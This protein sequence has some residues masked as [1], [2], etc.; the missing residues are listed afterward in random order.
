MTVVD[1][2]TLVKATMKMQDG[3][4]HQSTLIKNQWPSSLH[5]LFEN[6]PTKDAS[7]QTFIKSFCHKRCWQHLS[8]KYC[9]LRCMSSGWWQYTSLMFNSLSAYQQPYPNFSA[10][11]KQERTIKCTRRIRHMEKIYFLIVSH[12]INKDFVI[13][14]IWHMNIISQLPLFEYNHGKH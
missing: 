7:L 2:M 14:H 10:L 6:K 3:I 4:Y 8:L 5:N 1:R 12:H 13:D 11:E 9:Q